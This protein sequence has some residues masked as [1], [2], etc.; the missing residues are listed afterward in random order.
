MATQIPI[1]GDSTGN[2]RIDGG[3]FEASQSSALHI[4]KGNI[5]QIKGGIFK[6][7]YAGATIHNVNSLSITG[8]TFEGN[9]HGIVI[10]NIANGLEEILTGGTY[11]SS[12]LG[13]ERSAGAILVMGD[14]NKR[15][16]IF[17][18]LVGDN[19][20][21]SDKFEVR[22]I[23]TSANELGPSYD[24][25]SYIKNVSVVEGAPTAEQKIDKVVA[26]EKKNKQKNQKKK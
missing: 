3:I 24:Y 15:N 16:D 9:I 4:Q 10:S 5:I 21:Y 7:S 23:S 22:E 26:E 6:G 19:H 14:N 2:I 1:L 11:K 8:G 12:E 13:E 20:H 18:V 25:L 17:N